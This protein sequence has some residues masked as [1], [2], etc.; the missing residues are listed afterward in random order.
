VSGRAVYFISHPDVVVSADVPVTQ[1]PLS[2]TGIGRMR[3]ALAQPRVRTL[4]AL[5]SS[6]ETKAVVAALG[7]IDRGATGFLPPPE[8][9]R[10]ADAFFAQPEASVRGWERAV[11]AQ[12]RIVAAVAAI[13]R[14]DA[15][16]GAIG[17][18]SHGAV[19]ALLYCALTGA[20]IDRRF[21]Q[22]HRGGGCYLAFPAASPHACAWW[23]PIDAAVE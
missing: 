18:V 14:D 4:S 3:D 9:E 8:F 11:D 17:I 21:D 19:G 23:R 16:A 10:V 13:L 1:W 22:P 12:R 5:Y 6:T 15:S 2:A 20:R 7:E